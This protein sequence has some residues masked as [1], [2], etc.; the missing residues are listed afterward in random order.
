MLLGAHILTVPAATLS[1]ADVALLT[2]SSADLCTRCDHLIHTAQV[3]FQHREITRRLSK[4][5]AELESAKDDR[6]FKTESAVKHEM[7]VLEREESLLPPP[8]E[9]TLTLSDQCAELVQR[10]TYRCRDL[11]EAQLFAALD[12]LSAKLRAIKA[13]DL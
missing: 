6:D 2:H 8:E 4:L 12:T 10:V 9:D 7:K 5:R 13:L 11:A 1:K 3:A